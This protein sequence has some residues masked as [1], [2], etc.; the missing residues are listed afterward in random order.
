[1]EIATLDEILM[2]AAA[3]G[4]ENLILPR[5]REAAVPPEG[6]LGK[7][8]PGEGLSGQRE[9]VYAH[10]IL[11]GLMTKGCLV[12]ENGRA[13]LAGEMADFFECIKSAST[14]IIVWPRDQ[15]FSPAWSWVHKDQ[16]GV[17]RLEGVAAQPGAFRLYYE[18]TKDWC[19]EFCRWLK[20]D[21]AE[22]AGPVDVGDFDGDFISPEMLLIQKKISWL[23]DACPAGQPEKTLRRLMLVEE[24]MERLLVYEEGTRQ[25]RS[26][27]GAGL[28]K[29][30]FKRLLGGDWG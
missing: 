30:Y 28:F 18:T 4:M 20:D 2:M 3:A 23:W 14:M 5:F 26:P 16:I 13:V 27:A 15:E 8:P 19:Y 12:T 10:R 29:I 6:P 7:W 1:M 22:E 24:G 11:A 17:A 21:F 9:L 25:E